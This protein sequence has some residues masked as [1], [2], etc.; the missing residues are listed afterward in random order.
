MTTEEDLKKVINI[1]NECTGDIEDENTDH[2]PTVD[3]EFKGN[4]NTSET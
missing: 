3:L 2:K 1:N 4:D